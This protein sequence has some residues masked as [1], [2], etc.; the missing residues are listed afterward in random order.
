[1]FLE[2]SLEMPTPNQPCSPPQENWAGVP[3]RMRGS[4]VAAHRYSPSGECG[5]SSV[6]PSTPPRD[7]RPTLWLGPFWLSQ[8]SGGA[9]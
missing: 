3:G 8:E 5:L 2:V 6:P 7:P 4:Q 1:M 9:S